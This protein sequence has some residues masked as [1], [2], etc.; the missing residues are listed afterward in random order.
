M[1]FLSRLLLLLLFI[2]TINSCAFHSGVMSG[3]AALSNANF[4]VVDYAIGTAQTTHVLGIGGIGTEALVLEAK[5][6]LYRNH[7]LS[8]GQALGNVSVD[9][10]RSFYFVAS[11]LKVVV[12]ADIIDFNENA[13]VET[14]VKK[15]PIG[16]KSMK[17][18]KILI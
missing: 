10:K 14:E 6:N 16:V 8:S 5:R 15:F 1:K 17:E 12:S 3:S 11:T 9:F 4:K 2:I 13:V 18:I 7:P